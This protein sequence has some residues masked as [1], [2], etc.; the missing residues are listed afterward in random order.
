[1]P[2]SGAL[3]LEQEM[4][5]QILPLVPNVLLP[6]AATAS[7]RPHVPAGYGVQEQ[8][9]PFTAATS[10]GLLIRSP[11]T[12]GLCS[13]KDVPPGA[14]GFR[15]PLDPDGR[16]DPRM[17]FVKDDPDCRFA[18][19]AFGLTPIAFRDPKGRRNILRNVQ[20]GLSFFDRPD[21][22]AMFKIHLP[23]VLRTPAG[24]N[25]LFTAAINRESP[26]VI[27][28]GLVDTDWYAHPVNL[29]AR[30]PAHGD[31]HVAAG[32]VIAQV[33]FVP[34]DARKADARLVTSGSAEERAAQQDLLTWYARHA[35]DRSA[36]KRLAR[37]RHGEHA[38]VQP[39]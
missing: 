28:A 36:Y 20:P 10:L 25:S 29:V 19:N 2:A 1:V 34:R 4:D 31:L 22:Q 21:Q 35:Q 6:V 37:S 7:T 3:A 12:F 9:L 24:M 8:C 26:L 18:R 11:I 5:V 33:V 32:D 38:P 30:K 23:F 13:A 15:S 16:S 14:H 39:S 17:F 27:A